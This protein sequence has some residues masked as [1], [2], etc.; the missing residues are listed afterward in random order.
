MTGRRA[1]RPAGSTWPASPPAMPGAPSASTSRPGPAA[2]AAPIVLRGVGLSADELAHDLATS[3]ELDAPVAARAGRGLLVGLEEPGPRARRPAAAAR[4]PGPGGRVRGLRLTALPLP[5]GATGDELMGH[6]LA[7]L[8]ARWVMLASSAVAGHEERVRQF[9]RVFRALPASAVGPRATGPAAVRRGGPDLT[10]GSST[11]PSLANDTPYPVRARDAA[12]RATRA[13]VDDLGRSASPGPRGG[14]RWEPAGAR[15]PPLRGRRDPGR[16]SEVKVGPV[17][18]YPSEAVL[19]GMQAQYDELSGQLSR[20]SR[21]PPGGGVAGPPNPGFEPGSTPSVQLAG[22]PRAHGPRRLAGRRRP[23]R[24]GGG[25]PRRSRIRGA[26]ASGSTPRRPP[27]R[28][29]ATRFP[30]ERPVA[31]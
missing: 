22:R 14:R 26:A 25:R 28:S 16:G 1:T 7:A 3:P 29:S 24:H 8:D 15:P 4:R 2:K 9:A 31:P 12:R 21:T 23:G 5:E 18:P 10:A 17:T 20:L 11:L 27:R 19:A 30:A 6:A 13:T